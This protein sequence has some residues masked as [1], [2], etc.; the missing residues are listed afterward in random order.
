M[1]LSPPDIPRHVICKTGSFRVLHSMR[2]EDH[3]VYFPTP[4]LTGYLVPQF[5]H[6]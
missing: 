2:S 5:P 6:L 4:G 3:W 1:W